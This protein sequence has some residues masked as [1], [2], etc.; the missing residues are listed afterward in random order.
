MGNDTTVPFCAASSS[1]QVI[2]YYFI[3]QTKFRLYVCVLHSVQY[4]D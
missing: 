1:H 3:L 4:K 2:Q